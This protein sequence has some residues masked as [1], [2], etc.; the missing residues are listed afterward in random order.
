MY[1]AYHGPRGLKRIADRV[2][3]FAQLLKAG[4]ARLNEIRVEDG[5]FFDTLKVHVGTGRAD[6]IFECGCKV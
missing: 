4:L 3:G 5:L 6:F 2:H 1:G